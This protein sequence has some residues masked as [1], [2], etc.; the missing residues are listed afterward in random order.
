MG[1][2]FRYPS[3]SASVTISAVG[4]NGQPIPSDSILIAGEDPS[5]DL[6]Q[7]QTDGS[8]QLLISSSSLPLPTGAATSAK[9]D[10]Q[11]TL[12]TAG[13]ASLSSIDG[14]T[15][16]VGQKAMAASSPVVIASDQS[17]IAVTVGNFPATQPVSGTVTAN[18][19][20]SWTV[21]ANAGTNLNTSALN[22]ETT[23]A[24]MSAK[25]PATLGQKAMAASLAVV[26]ASDQSTVPVSL[27]S[28]PL[29]T[30]A[31]TSA[32]QSS[33]QGTVAAGTAATAS[34]LVGGVFNTS[35]PT[36]TNGQ[37]AAAQLDSSGRRIIAPLT[38]SS[39]VK[40]QLQDNSGT[41]I[42]VG[43]TTMS[44]SVP[45]AIASNQASIP[46][47]AT[48]VVPA[49]LTV[50]Q[51][52]VSVGTSA[53]RLTT[54]GSA[55]SST[56]RVLAANVDSAVTAK[57]YIGSSSVTATSTTRG[58]QL[59]AGQSFIANE[60]AGDYYIISDTAGQTVFVTEQE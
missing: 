6:Q 56:R 55:P 39:I 4:Q 12:E 24:A 25:L 58:I 60:D 26:I 29:P 19:G 43:Q 9:Q 40:A 36:L 14:K 22:L 52:A 42:V 5:G 51:A 32:L 17:S 3:G 8:G 57:F 53:V 59:V 1:Q 11:I 37:Q 47:A 10:S 23:Q 13:N 35:L 49:A 41:A 18:Q 38:N 21:T 45:V 2:L 27:A 15:P 33:T 48:P 28:S 30:G 7:L 44:A 31:S 50:K 54:D 46:V 16:T 34:T 20:G